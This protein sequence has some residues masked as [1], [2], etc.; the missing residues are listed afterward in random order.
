MYKLKTIIIVT[1]LFITTAI[2]FVACS[3]SDLSNLNDKKDLN[4]IE[5]ILQLRNSTDPTP[6]QNIDNYFFAL[7]DMREK[8]L[9]RLDKIS[10]NQAE[11][12][13]IK[14][15]HLTSKTTLDLIDKQEL[16]TILGYEDFQSFEEI[17]DYFNIQ[18]ELMVTNFKNGTITQNQINN[19]MIMKANVP[20]NA[21]LNAFN[22][23]C[24]DALIDAT[25]CLLVST[26]CGPFIWACG[27][28]CLL[29]EYK[30]LNNCK[31][32]YNACK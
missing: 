24:D 30:T 18:A 2:I 19:S 21:C 17:W 1:I 6:Q 13:L 4:D 20:N 9:N 8:Y 10:D 5:N 3:K 7:T 15:E 31:I 32:T 23:C 29:L 25:A 26:A 14:F 12:D 27:S 22:H 28:A 16:S 11:L